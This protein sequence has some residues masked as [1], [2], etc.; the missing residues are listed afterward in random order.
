M[1]G[2]ECTDQMSKQTVKCA[3]LEGGMLAAMQIGHCLA[4][5]KGMLCLTNI[6]IIINLCE[7]NLAWTASSDGTSNNYIGYYLGPHLI[8]GTCCFGMDIN[9]NINQYDLNVMTC[10]IENN[11]SPI[12]IDCES[13][14]NN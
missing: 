13:G 11:Y 12:Y 1:A 5:I 8:T 9:H 4:K 14:R 10:D 7:F 2:I 3:I 6:I